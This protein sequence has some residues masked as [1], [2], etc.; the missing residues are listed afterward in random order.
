[1]KY[2]QCTQKLPIVSRVRT[3]SSSD[4]NSQLNLLHCT[5]TEKIMTRGVRSTGLAWST[6]L[7]DTAILQLVV[8]VAV[9]FRSFAISVQ[10][11]CNYVVYTLIFT[12]HTQYSNIY[13]QL[14]N[15]FNVLVF[16]FTVYILDKGS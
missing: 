5:V 2:L 10:Y 4:T 8:A 15:C 7:Y 3:D 1:M 16:R 11:N 6:D 12:V 14:Y 13:V 9:F